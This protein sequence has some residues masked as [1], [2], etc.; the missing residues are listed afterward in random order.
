VKKVLII[1][2]YWPPAGG[3]PVQRWVKM[4]RYLHEF[5]W[6]PV[7][8][9]VENGEQAV[10]DHTL[11]ATL[12]ANLEVIRRPIWEPYSA[13]RNLLGMRQD[14]K[15]N[16]AF[17][18]EKKKKSWLQELAVWIR[19]NFFIPDAR[20]FW[21]K[22]SVSFLSDYLRKHPVDAIISTG[23]PH[24][25]H[26]IALGV[27]QQTGI[28]W[29][30]DFRD[31]WTNIDYYTSLHL[32]RWADKKHHALEKMVISGADKVV[33]VS[34]SWAADFA[35]MYHRQVDVVTNG[36]DTHDYPEQPIKLDTSFT[37]HHVGM[38]NK[39]RNPEVLWK[40]IA[41]LCAQHTEFRQDVQIAF[42]GKVD[43]SVLDMIEQYGLSAHVKQYGH[44]DHP[45]AIAHMRAAG[46]LLLLVNDAQDIK[47]RVPAKLFEYMAAQRPIVAIGDPEGDAA[48]I[49]IETGCGVMHGLQDEEGVY[50]TLE[51]CYQ[52]WKSGTLQ[53]T[54]MAPEKYTRRA[55]AGQ[56][57][58]LLN[59]L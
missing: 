52:Q 34:K 54:R 51:T 2:Y 25:M 56:Y 20:R 23:P 8:Y 59:A 5:G 46:V 21:I 24:S 1:T 10:L 47:G 3:V 58:Q 57:A 41:R 18:Q 53:Q 50:Q 4:A 48:A 35:S 28:P 38:I 33:T 55:L 49:L 39:A 13:Y 16:A 45:V 22:P 40:A 6:E 36:F 42:T 27:K 15:I 11:A 31:P 17:L 29:I 30:A 32:S 44:V 7:I 14:E 43:H 12:P 26:M 19:G 37:L 9:T